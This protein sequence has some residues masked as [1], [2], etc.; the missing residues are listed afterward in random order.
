[1]SDLTEFEI[2]GGGGKVI[3]RSPLGFKVLLLIRNARE[4]QIG[5]HLL[6]YGSRDEAE[7]ALAKISEWGGY[8]EAV[9]LYE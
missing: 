7:T 5:S 9:R 3:R 2:G 4:G 1:M 6:E 8:H